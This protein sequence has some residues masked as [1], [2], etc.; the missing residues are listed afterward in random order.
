M[1]RRSWRHRLPPASTGASCSKDRDRASFQI[2]AADGF[3]EKQQ[4]DTRKQRAVL[5]CS[6]AVLISRPFR[7]LGE[8]DHRT[9]HQEASTERDR[10]HCTGAVDNTQCSELLHAL[11]F[12]P[13]WTVEEST[14][15]SCESPK[16][17]PLTS[18]L[19]ICQ[20]SG[21]PCLSLAIPGPLILQT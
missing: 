6:L 10:K 14:S 18:I 4:C 5:L 11:P 15:M 13:A 2:F 12:P 21:V 17:L 9:R 20:M 1:A 16:P 7:R 3:V 19:R 8:L